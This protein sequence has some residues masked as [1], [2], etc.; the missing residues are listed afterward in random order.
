MKRLVPLMAAALLAG[1]CQPEAGPDTLRVDQAWVRLAPV[2]GRPAAAYF[3]VRGGESDTRL[4]AVTSPEADRVELHESRMDGGM[5]RMRPLADVPVPAG[6]ELAF[7][8]GGR[9]AMLFGLS[10]EVRP[11]GRL[12]LRF[13]FST[14]EELQV[15]AFVLEAGAPAPQF[16][17]AEPGPSCEPEM[18]REGG[19]V[20]IAEC[21]R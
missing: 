14:G 21:G 4:A 18:R 17:E 11:F 15:H 16:V 2:P 13:R 19:N 20:I 7:A 1:A 3:T 10:G 5:S 12:P 8:P 9:H 6:G